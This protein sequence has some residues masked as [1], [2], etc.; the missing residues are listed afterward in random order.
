M[1]DILPSSCDILI[2]G[3]GNA[4]FSAA[5]SATQT[6][7]SASILLIDKC[8]STWAG[9][10]SYFTAGAFR[11]VHNGLPDL[12]PLVNN[13]S[14]EEARKTCD[15]HGWMKKKSSSLMTTWKPRL[16]ILRG[17]R[18]SYYYAETDTEEAFRFM[19]VIGWLG[20]LK[21][22]FLYTWKIGASLRQ[23]DLKRT[24]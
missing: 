16:F 24:E 8:P 7:P 4:G 18:L 6:N 10:N 22:R 11:T 3:T 20:P 5:L 19:H 9:G 17:R 23:R 1:S 21:A 14:P 12:L 13:A 15:Y 2:I